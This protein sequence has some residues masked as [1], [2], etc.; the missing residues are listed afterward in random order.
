MGIY[1]EFGI[2]LIINVSVTVTR[3]GGVPV[4]IN[5]SGNIGDLYRNS[6][7]TCS[8]GIISS[9]CLPNLREV[10]KVAS[11]YHLPVLVDAAIEL[12]LKR[13]L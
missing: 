6:P 11:R 5:I 8:S 7:Y 13:D 2:T 4:P 10:L 3:L 12:P 9:L 1:Q